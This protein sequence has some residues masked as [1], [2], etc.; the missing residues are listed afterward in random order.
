MDGLTVPKNCLKQ[1]TAHLQEASEWLLSS[2]VTLRMQS[3]L[4]SLY[5]NSGVEMGR[6][7]R[8]MLMKRGW[9]KDS[10]QGMVGEIF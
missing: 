7:T 4:H 2:G 3:N 9:M 8:R 1:T 10:S 6:R 5:S